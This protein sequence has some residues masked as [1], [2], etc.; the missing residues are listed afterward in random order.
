MNNFR[1]RSVPKF[2]SW[3]YILPG[4]PYHQTYI[5]ILAKILRKTTLYNCVCVC[6]VELYNVVFQF[7]SHND[8]PK[9]QCNTTLYLLF[10]FYIMFWLKISWDFK[11][12]CLINDIFKFVCFFTE[13]LLFTIFYFI[14]VLGSW[15]TS[16]WM[17]FIW[18]HI[19]LA[20]FD[21]PFLYN[22]FFIVL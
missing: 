17:S 7:M 15:K 5:N 11:V 16:L 14:V 19:L 1:M 6:A 18:I 22:R 12:L 20:W 9:I 2:V 3:L 21:T 13:Y 8:Y 4:Q 10:L